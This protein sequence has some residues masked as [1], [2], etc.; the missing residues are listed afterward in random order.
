MTFSSDSST[1]YVYWDFGDGD[2]SYFTSPEHIFYEPGFH[3]V[4]L[5]ITNDKQCTESFSA[6]VQVFANPI[7]NFSMNPNP[8]TMLNSTVNFINLSTLF[9]PVD[10]FNWDFGEI[11]SSWLKD[12]TY[13]FSEDT[14]GNHIINLEVIDQ[15]GCKNSTTQILS[16]LGN[17]GFYMPTGFSPNGD[18]LNDIF[19]PNGF[20]ILD[21]EFSFLVYD[22]W[23][24]LIF[25][26]HNKNLGW[27]GTFNG[28]ILP[29]G[30]YVWKLTFLNL[31][32]I[33]R[34]E[35]GHINLIK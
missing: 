10:T 9:A 19:T 25:E 7:A 6:N 12:P 27:D 21:E 1:P 15:N 18:G 26:S 4:S 22:R 23:G 5:T 32:R 17:F 2:Y 20:G 29:T 34:T 33:S 30:S 13:S 3:T 16:I 24:I 11:S 14:T 8:A 35:T 28:D 31:E